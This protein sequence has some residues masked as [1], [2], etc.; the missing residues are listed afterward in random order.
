[1]E[2]REL[3]VQDDALVRRYHEIVWRAEME[4]GRPW[5]TFQSYEELAIGLREPSPGQRAD[6]LG[7]FDGDEMVGGGIVW[8]SLEDN[9]DKAF[10][11]PA[12]EPDRRG[13]GIGGEL[14]EGMV[15]HVRGLG[16]TKVMSG[17]S[18]RFEEREDSP[19]DRFAAAHGFAPANLEVVRQLALPVADGLLAEIEAETTA[20]TEGYEVHSFVDDIPEELVESYCWLVNQLALDAP[21]GDLEFEEE[22]YTP[23]AFRHDVARD[24]KVGRSVLRSVAVKD[25]HAVAHSDLLLR[26][27]GTRGVQWATLVHR[28]HRGHRLGAAVKAANLRRLQADRPDITEVVTQNAEVNEQMIGINARLG[29]EPVAL[30]PEYLRRL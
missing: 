21:T 30:V 6:A 10:V 29:F 4:D 9:L 3:D 20:H 14:L 23:E 5:N 1:M 11:F 22:A 19:M 7:I 13:H 26:P 28:E 2:I 15:E 18:I 27:S 12:V 24:R 16:R 8:L 25:G 17:T